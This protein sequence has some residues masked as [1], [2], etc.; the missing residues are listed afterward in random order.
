[1]SVFAGK[2]VIAILTRYGIEWR[3]CFLSSGPCGVSRL[4]PS[5]LEDG[6]MRIRFTLIQRLLGPRSHDIGP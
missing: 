6:S 2:T 5:V 4:W 3:G 1:M